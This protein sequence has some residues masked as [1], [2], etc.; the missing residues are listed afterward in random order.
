MN[1]FAVAR[2][3]R[4]RG[5]LGINRRNAEYILANNPRLAVATVDDK[6]RLHRL[7]A[8]I[9][10]PTPQ[11]Y[12]V[13]ER[14]S[15]LRRMPDFLFGL[16][17]FAIKPNRGSGGRGI[18]VV[19]GRDG[20][21]FTLPSGKRLD[22]DGL[23]HH[24]GEVLA[25]LYSLGGRP[26]VALVQ[27]RVRLHPAFVPIAYQG[28][29]DVRVVVYRGEAAMAMLRLPTRESR[30]RANLHQGGIGVGIDL[31]TGRTV[32]AV[33]G[34]GSVSVHPDT[35]ASLVGRV[36]PE[37]PTVLTMACRVAE[38]VGLGYS[39]VDFVLDADAGPLLLE[40]NARPGLAIQ[41]ANA[42]GL[43]QR[44]DAIDARSTATPPT[45]TAIRAA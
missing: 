13:V 45:P 21:G 14:H 15:Q 8:A 12:A 40:A 42:A 26:D 25:G 7:C 18:V 17:G 1:W 31:A 33:R 34:N 43:R 35:G 11:V 41:A 27:Q 24:I 4:Q 9:Q 2:Q 10:V 23:R 5:V 38:A 3:L 20:P 22:V 19:D 39:G 30:G 32:N 6:L 44:L 16:D 29:P 36:V 37:W 28:I